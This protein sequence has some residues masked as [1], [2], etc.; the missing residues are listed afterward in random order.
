MR[1]QVARAAWCQKE[2]IFEQ[3]W[4]PVHSWQLCSCSR[5]LSLDCVYRFFIII[6]I[7]VATATCFPPS[8]PVFLMCF[9]NFPHLKCVCVHRLCLQ[10][11]RPLP[12]S[13][14]WYLVKAYLF[15]CSPSDVYSFSGVFPV[16]ISFPWRSAYVF[17]NL[18]V[19][20]THVRR[21]KSVP[22]VIGQLAFWFAD[23]T[24]TACVFEQIRHE[25][26]ADTK[27]ETLGYVKW[28]V[29]LTA[30][31][32]WTRNDGNLLS[33]WPWA[34]ASCFPGNIA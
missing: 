28:G 11:V 31:L 18:K 19:K 6:I 23:G 33:A 22:Q 27:W 17:K 32:G 7:V 25:V 34:E 15:Q 16:A 10:H 5:S 4:P 8:R 24:K 2:I 13:P 14:W 9:N 3:K 29:I 21:L 1:K 26:F 30:T 20:T 12:E